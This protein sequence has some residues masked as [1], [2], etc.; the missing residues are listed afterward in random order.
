MKKIGKYEVCGLLGKGGMGT[1]YKVRMP[2]VGKIVA[3]KLLAPHPNLIALMGEEE[4]KRLFV[5]EA[6]TMAGLR[7]PNIV[8][9]WDFHESEDLTYFVMEYFCNNLGVIIGETYLVEE[10]SRMV[11]VD[12]TLRYARE[13]LEGLSRLHQ[14]GIIHRDIKPFNILVTDQDTAKITDFGLSKLRGE[15]FEGPQNLNVGS[16]YYA[17]PEQEEDPNTVDVRADLYPVGIM[18]Y[19]MLTGTLPIDSYKSLSESN[20]DLDPSWDDFLKKA[21]ATKREERFRSANEMLGAL[22]TLRVAWEQKKDKV[23]EMPPEEVFIK[24]PPSNAEGK[25]RRESVKVRPGEARRVFGTD[26]RWRP[27]KY[28]T[29]DFQVNGDGTVSDRATGL[30]WEQAGSDFPMT[31]HEACDY[32]KALNQK[33]FAGRDNWRLPTI[34][35]LMTLLS[36]VP[37]AGDLCIAPVFDQ[38][39]RWLWS[40]DRRSFVAAWYVSADMGYVSWQ[41]FSCCYYVRAVFSET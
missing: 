35:E 39:E 17:P 29:N 13:I 41:D 27:A 32:V 10:P 16:P 2:V 40:S 8:D 33:P 1:V 12:K 30:T 22:D 21:I 6:V 9:I 36:D 26:N 15:I 19:R 4:L 7:H 18:L 24:G 28:V 5:T 31:W 34:N 20:P 14:A 11:S 23:C 37:R 3:L 38:S 25:P